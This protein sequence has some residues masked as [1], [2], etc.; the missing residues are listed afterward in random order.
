MNNN[1]QKSVLIVDDTPENLDVLKGLLSPDYRILV[2]TNGRTALRVALSQ[3]PPDIILLD[4]MMP[5]M[6]GY[7]ACRLL[8]E[9]ERT[10]EIPILFMTARSDVEDEVRGFALGAVDYLTKP[11]TPAVV[12]ARVRTHLAMRDQQKLLS[13]QVNLRTA[14]L[15]VRN[16][17]LEETRQEVIRQLGRAAEYRDNETGLHIMRMSRYTRLLALRYGLSEPEA[18]ELMIAAPLHDVGKIGIPDNILLKPGKLTPEEFSVMQRHPEIGFEIVGK[19]VARVLNLGASIAL[20]HHEKWNGLGYPQ[21]LLGEAIPLEG[22][23][24]AVADVFDALTSVRPYKKAWTIEDALALILRSA[25]EHFDPMLAE[26]FV[27][28]RSE[29]VAIMEQYQETK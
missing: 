6:D 7:E 13:H 22:R 25:G 28:L 26:I 9:E 16:L 12:Q 4:I 24:T 21:G 15:Q 18:E 14:Q 5:V 23:I 17:E 10:R 8:K 27:G 3:N 19:Q 29:I 11:I 2:A 1:A 20:T